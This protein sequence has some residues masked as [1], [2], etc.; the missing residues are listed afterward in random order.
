MPA[1]QSRKSATRLAGD[2]AGI[3]GLDVAMLANRI[4]RHANSAATSPGV[5]AMAGPVTLADL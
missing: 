2:R 1:P 3:D 4:L 5:S